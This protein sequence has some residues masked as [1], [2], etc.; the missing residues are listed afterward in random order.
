MEY[1]N[2]VEM[3]YLF[4]VIASVCIQIFC[5]QRLSLTFYREECKKGHYIA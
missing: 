2:Q 5:I 3:V 1:I 4:Q